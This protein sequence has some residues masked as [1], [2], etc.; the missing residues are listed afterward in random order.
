MTVHLPCG[1]DTEAQGHDQ[2]PSPVPASPLPSGSSAKAASVY[3]APGFPG[4]PV[5]KPIHCAKVKMALADPPPPGPGAKGC[6]Q[7]LQ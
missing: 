4:A 2:S 6:G 7:G 1:K 5:A 3:S